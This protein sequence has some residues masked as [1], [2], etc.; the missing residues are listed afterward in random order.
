MDKAQ[1]KRILNGEIIMKPIK[2]YQ[3]KFIALLKEAEEELGG[4]LTVTVR[5][6]VVYQMPD[7]NSISAV[8]ESKLKESRREYTCSIGTD[9]AGLIL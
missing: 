7:Y 4:A 2:K 1:E 9:G 3:E 6:R 8:I 5:D